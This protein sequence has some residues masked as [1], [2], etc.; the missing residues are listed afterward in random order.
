MGGKRGGGFKLEAVA[1]PASL[2]TDPRRWMALA[3]RVRE[4]EMPPKGAPAAV[5]RRA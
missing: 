5:A 1:E 3:N 2:R 4:L